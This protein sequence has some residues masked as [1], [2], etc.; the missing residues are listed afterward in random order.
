MQGL[1]NLFFIL[2]LHCNNALKRKPER[3]C[4]KALAFRTSGSSLVVRPILIKPGIAG[5][6]KA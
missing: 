4:Y 3:L 6:L 5:L 1:F 2:D